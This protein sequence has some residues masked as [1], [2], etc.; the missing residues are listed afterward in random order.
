MFKSTYDDTGPSEK[1]LVKDVKKALSEDI[2]SGD[3]TS[4]LID[5]KHKGFATI[6]CKEKAILCGSPYVNATYNLLDSAV[7][8]TW[9]VEDGT[10]VDNNRAVCRI[11]GNTKAILTGERTAINFLQTLSGTATTTAKY[12][13]QVKNSNT[14]ILDTRKTIPGLREA[15]KYAVLCGGGKNH[16]KGL[17]DGILIKENHIVAAGSIKN[18]VGKMRELRPDLKIEVEVENADEVSQALEAKADIILLDNFEEK[19][20]ANILPLPSD[21]TKVEISGN[22]SLERVGDLSRLGV[23]FIS[24]GALTKNIK[25]IDFSLRLV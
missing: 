3:I 22:V 7:K 9:M 1:E 14:K 4:T 16:R 6:I 10:Q 13:A 25:A 18:A 2:G 17:F 23:D 19:T 8:I 20:L 5:N 12:V 21:K 24:V 15:Q 11:E